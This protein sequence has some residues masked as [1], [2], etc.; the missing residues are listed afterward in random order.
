M[1]LHF[2]ETMDEVLKIALEREICAL[3][4][5]TNIPGGEVVVAS[6]RRRSWRTKS[7]ACA[8]GYGFLSHSKLL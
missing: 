6:H 8:N 2:V 4:M 7:R 3:P 1:K 5:P